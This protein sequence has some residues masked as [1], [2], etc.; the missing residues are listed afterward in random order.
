MHLPTIRAALLRRRAALLHRRAALMRPSAARRQGRVGRAAGIGLGAALVF[1]AALRFGSIAAQ[2]PGATASIAPS[3]PEPQ[4]N[5]A[6]GKDVYTGHCVECHG[7]MGK[8]DGPASHLLTPRPR[9]FTLARYKIRSTETGSIPTEADLQRSVQKGLP[10]STMPGWA[11]ILSDGDIRDVVAYVMT[12][13]PRFVAETPTAVAPTPAIASSPDSVERGAMVYGKLQCGKCHGNDGRGT[14]AVA[15]TF[16]DDWRQPLRAADLT[17]PWV[18]HGGATAADIYMRFR[19]G[20]SGTPMPSFKEAATDADMWDLSNYVVSLGRKPLWQMNAQEV[21]DFY[22]REDAFWKANPA[23]RGQ[24]LVD[25]LGCAACHSPVDENERLIPGLAMAGGLRLRLEPFGDYPT[26]NL[27]SDK[28]TGLGTWTDDEIKAVLTRGTLR[29][30]TRLLP[31]PMDWPSY[32]TMKPDDLNAIVVYLRTIPPVSNKVPHLS[33]TFLP[34]YLWGKFKML[35]LGGDPPM[36]FS[37]GNAGTAA[38]GG[39]K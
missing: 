25:T 38:A 4:G 8:G 27:T 16:E 19:V 30:G 20:M 37:A 17:E 31:Y 32:S 2:P 36:I 13:S 39:A 35:V 23:K 22:A 10:G 9:D 28:E 6:H 21:A 29:D 3:Q 18:F 11:A 12:L 15:T 14:G 7:A 24:Y 1:V 34:L 26:G 33:R 5:S